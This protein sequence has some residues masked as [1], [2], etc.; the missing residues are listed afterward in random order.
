MRLQ[1]QPWN[2]ATTNLGWT[3]DQWTSDQVISTEPGDGHQGNSYTLRV[4]IKTL[5]ALRY[6]GFDLSGFRLGHTYD[7][8]PRL[9]ELLI[10]GGCAEPAAPQSDGNRGADKTR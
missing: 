2:V 1:E 4:R 10:D 7:V 6:E 9:A 8:E 5:P 3:S